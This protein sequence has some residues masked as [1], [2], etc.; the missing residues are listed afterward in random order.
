MLEKLNRIPKQSKKILLV[1]YIKKLIDKRTNLPI[2]SNEYWSKGTKNGYENLINHIEKYE[3]RKKLNISL[4]TM[5]EELY[6]DYFKTINDIHK[7]ENGTP[8]IRTT[9]AKD[10]KN[11]KVIFNCAVED[12][13]EVGFN[14]SKKGLKIHL[15]KPMYETYLTN[16]QLKKIINADVSHSAELQRAKDYIIISSF[17]GGLRIGDMKHLHELKVEVIEF[18][19]K[20]YNTVTTKIRKSKENQDELIVTI[21]IL[22][23]ANDILKKYQNKFPKL[24]SD[25]NVRKCVTKLLKHLKFENEV[26]VSY[27]YYLSDKVIYKKKKQHSVFSPHDCRRTYITN[28]KQLG[29]QNDTI[30]P[31]THP[32]MN[33]KSVLDSY[34]KS[35]LKDKAIKLIKAIESSN[36]KLYKI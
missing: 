2:S 7:E 20:H 3:E 5:T 9:I 15:S 33:Y 16:E 26:L 14:F 34:D 32:K 28:L 21:P 11:L 23:P 18:E 6:W 19:G 8:Y 10:C 27:D 4:D 24:T 29:I 30:E 31:I 17:T 1:E 22:K 25:T 12:D 35:T 13:I 36:S